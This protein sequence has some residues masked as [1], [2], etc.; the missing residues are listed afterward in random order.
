MRQG[1]DA[2]LGNPPPVHPRILL[3]TSAAH[4][5]RARIIFVTEGMEVSAFA[6]SFRAKPIV[7]RTILDFVPR[8]GAFAQSEAAWRELCGQWFY[9]LGALIGD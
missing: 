7:M 6:V 4:M 2:K 3:V 8:A 9:Q 5:K 1:L